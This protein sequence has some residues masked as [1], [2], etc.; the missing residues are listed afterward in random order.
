MR[1]HLVHWERI[2]KGCECVKVR[3]GHEMR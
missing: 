3:L 1:G 2:G